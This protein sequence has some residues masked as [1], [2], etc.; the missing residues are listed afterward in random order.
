MKKDYYEVL[1]VAK[2]ARQE[3]VKRAYR[4]LALKWHPD[5]N[6]DN[7]EAE[8]R[9]KEAS[10]AYSVLGDR[11]KRAEYDAYGHNMGADPGWDP[12][13]GF[14]NHFG[15]DIFEEF[16]GRRHTAGHRRRKS[17]EPRGSDILINMNLS[18]AESVA[19][20]SRDIVVDRTAKCQVC[21]GAGGEGVDVCGQ[22]RGTGKIQ[23]RQGSMVM[24]TACNSCGGSGK[25]VQ[26]KCK[27]CS[28]KG[29]FDE[30]SSINVRIPAGITSGQQLR[31]S[32]LG[33]YGKGGTGDLFIN[34][35]VERSDKFEKRGKDIFTKLSLTVSEAALGCTKSV[36]TIH[37][38]KNVNIPAGSQPD[39][40]LRLAGLGIPDVH[41]GSPG[42]HKI[43]IKI[44]V[45]KSLTKE[46]RELFTKLRST[47]S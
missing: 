7:P 20:T 23:F 21:D 47:G 19:G 36:E 24:Q 42:D 44:V 15:S 1:G 39:S 40:M 6:P 22:C 29:C 11:Q 27:E 30:P 45:P 37:G 5:K 9:F 2:G 38:G 33:H 12:F 32:K 26:T 34:V 25:T 43:E 14:R 46:Q 10:E 35:S 31:L 17:A 16:F 8:E 28:G 41:G 13:E 4:K 3:D 18:F